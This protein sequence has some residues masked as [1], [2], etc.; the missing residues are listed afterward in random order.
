MGNKNSYFVN[1]VEQ[2]LRNLSLNNDIEKIEKL[3]KYIG[4]NLNVLGLVSKSQVNA[5]K[6]GFSF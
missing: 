6:N 1:E 2:T 4:T 3:K 5:H